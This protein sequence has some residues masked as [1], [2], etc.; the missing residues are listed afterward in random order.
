MS[1][2]RRWGLLLVVAIVIAALPAA[3]SSRYIL[4]ALIFIALNAIAALGL[5]LV[6]G[7][8]GQVSLGQA[9]FYAIG[10]YVSGV[11]TATYGWNGWAALALA[12]V[13]GGVTAFVV[14][15]PIFKLSG[16]LLA[17]ATL[18]FGIIVYY[19]LVNWSGVTGGPSGLTSIPPLSIGRLRLD[20]DARMFWLTWGCLLF[21]LGLAGNLVD[22][23]VG[24][25]LRAIHG[26]EPAAQAVGID[27]TSY[28]LGIFTVAGA[29]TALA[30]GLYA[31]YLTFINP[32]P[33]GFAYSIELLLMVVLGGVA[34][35]W[36]A[37]LGAALVVVLVEALRALSPLLTVS[38][39]AAEYEIVLFGLILMALMVFVPQGLSGIFRRAT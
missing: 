35:L 4:S 29:I 14:G 28:K 22:S 30:G 12:V 24:R 33:F 37:L 13:M 15:L 16:L 25:A 32:S 26:S 20:S 17:M 34:S 2:R 7:F 3:V 5:T 38:H 9:A 23:R 21:L 39:G 36:G 31:H 6:M 18:G 1:A 11:L 10:A 19:I 8:A 27:T